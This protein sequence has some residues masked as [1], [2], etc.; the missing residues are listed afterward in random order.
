MRAIK[1][2][3]S[4]T[5]KPG[6]RVLSRGYGAVNSGMKGTFVGYLDEKQKDIWLGFTFPGLDGH[7]LEGRISTYNGYWVDP[8]SVRLLIPE[9]ENKP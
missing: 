1:V 8:Y 4:H 3:N 5:Y 9:P 7:R 6:D 2:G